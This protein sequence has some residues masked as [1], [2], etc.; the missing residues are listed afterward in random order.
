MDEKM[1]KSRQ[2]KEESKTLLES[3]VIVF[4]QGEVGKEEWM[5]GM[6]YTGSK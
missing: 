5:N 1:E 4:F 6:G 3:R 2:R